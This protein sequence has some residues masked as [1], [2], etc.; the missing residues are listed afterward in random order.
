MPNLQNP[1]VPVFGGAAFA[2]EYGSAVYVLFNDSHYERD[3]LG[4]AEE[5]VK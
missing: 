2:T 3:S 4:S 5:Y 1:Q